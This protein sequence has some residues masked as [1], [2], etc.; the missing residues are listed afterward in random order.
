MIPTEKKIVAAVCGG[1]LCGKTSLFLEGI[2][3]WAWRRHRL[4]CIVF[5]RFKHEHTWPA[6]CWV[7]TRKDEFLR[8]VTKVPGCCVIW[9][10]AT[11]TFD[12][13]DPED[14][15][16]VTA[17]RHDHPAFFM[18]I[19][20]VKAMPPVIRGSI[21]SAFVFRQIKERAREWVNIF[22]DEDLAQTA[23]LAQYEWIH[24]A[25]FRPIVRRRPTVDQLRTMDFFP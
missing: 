20:D 16:K 17:I 12:A 9:D 22:A 5:D 14:V 25:A 15:D 6:W 1:T 4:R 23:T 21:K 13:N 3:Y 10:E 24:K 18:G 2:V 11:T 8:A 19:H 7:T